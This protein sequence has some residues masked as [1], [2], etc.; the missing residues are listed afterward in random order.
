[1][2]TTSLTAPEWIRHLAASSPSD[3]VARMLDG[4]SQWALNVAAAN[5]LVGLVEH[6]RPA[7]VLEFGAGRSSLVLAHALQQNGGGRLTSIEHQPRYSKPEWE[8][9]ARYSDVDARL[10]VAPLKLRMTRHG[11]LY[12][13]DGIAPA[14][15]SRG[16][17]DLVLVD[18][19]PG[20]FGR[21]WPFYAAA[22]FL[23]AGALVM[24]DDVER[25]QEQT[26]LRRWARALP[27]ESIGEV[28]SADGRRS[29][30]L[31][32]AQPGPPAFAWRTFLGTCHD[33]VLH[34]A[35]E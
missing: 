11:P 5:T 4:A 28:A 21:D 7:S 33:R 30:V 27:I 13:Y 2:L 31:R 6:F 1:M 14:L 24:L 12:V 9:V 8:G 34:R 3:A 19:P 32:L 25:A 29:A 35:R 20:E 18:A 23:S 17:F 26:T 15:T 16:P 22:P 10:V